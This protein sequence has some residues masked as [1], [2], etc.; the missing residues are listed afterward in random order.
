METLRNKRGKVNT[1]KSSEINQDLISRFSC[2]G[3]DPV[4]APVVFRYDKRVIA[5]LRVEKIQI[6]RRGRVSIQGWAFGNV[7]LSIEADGEPV[8]SE[9]ER[10]LRPDVI[11][12][13]K[14]Q[15][16]DG[17]LGFDLTTRAQ[18]QR[19]AASCAILVSVQNGPLQELFR[20]EIRI[21][22]VDKSNSSSAG[23]IRPAGFLEVANVSPVSGD[24]V[25]VG[26]VMHS[27]GTKVWFENESSEIFELEKNCFRVE[28]PDV[29]DAFGTTFGKCITKPGFIILL[30]GFLPG[31][32]IELV[33]EWEGERIVISSVVP[34]TLPMSSAAAA[35]FLFGLSTPT[36]QMA[37]RIGL[38]DFPIIADLIEQEHLN[39]QALATHTRQLG[40]PPSSPVVAVVVPLYGRFDFVEHQL[41]EFSRDP[42]FIDNVELVYVVD[43]PKIFDSFVEEAEAL[44]R[45][46]KL[47][48]RWVW[49]EI[50]RGFSGANNLG[51][52]NSSAPNLLFLNSD[53]FPQ[54]AG[55]LQHM[56]EA[57]TENYDYA[58]IGPR[59]T[60]SDGSIQHAGMA[61][62]RKEEWGIWTNDHPLM[63]LDPSLDPHSQLSSV[64]AVTGACILVR[65]SD[66]DSVGGWDTG[67]LIGDFEDSDLC[68]KLR[69]EGRK[70]GYLPSVQLTHLE[71]QS[72]KL[73]GRDFVAQRTVIYNAVRHQN[74][75]S[76][77]ISALNQVS[78]DKA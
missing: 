18:W 68:L 8:A 69:A 23:A 34:G 49:G 6:S 21:P 55:W 57:L 4:E 2:D 16:Y 32:P 60:H 61:F 71:R 3:D 11:E 52:V 9:L 22:G 74:R 14:L 46:Y 45:L 62:K 35:Q 78:G 59:L 77:E 51:A 75:W 38:I 47:P 40:Q 44:Y 20:F 54:T 36:R 15:N 43:D 33:S 7:G 31:E 53:C 19:D 30:E 27:P 42:W 26:W 25:V 64:P 10:S 24:A 1:R 13:L 76:K 41:I 12:H 72:F 17:N 56:L 66:F 29:L 28:R 67:Y 37:D 39:W 65:R 5:L 48:F 58:A 50:N 73:L 70:I 63:G